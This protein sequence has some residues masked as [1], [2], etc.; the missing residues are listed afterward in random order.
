MSIY[1]SLLEIMSLHWFFQLLS[2]ITWLILAFPLFMSVPFLPSL[3]VMN[4][5]PLSWIYLLDCSISWCVTRLPTMPAIF[6]ASAADSGLPALAACLP[7]PGGADWVS[8]LCPVLSVINV[9]QKKIFSFVGL[10]N[11][12]AMCVLAGSD[13]SASLTGRYQLFHGLTCHPGFS[14]WLPE[15]VILKYRGNVIDFGARI[16]ML[17]LVCS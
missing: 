10:E 11:S 15:V 17:P 7:R 6:L 9:I 8:P 14:V 13:H 12:K 4:L 5:A 3:I 1:L 16:L 2:N